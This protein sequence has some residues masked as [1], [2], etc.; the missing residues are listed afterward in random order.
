MTN[1]DEGL[2]TTVQFPVRSGPYQ[3][4]RVRSDGTSATLPVDEAALEAGTASASVAGGDTIVEVALSSTS[5]PDLDAPRG[6]LWP[7]EAVP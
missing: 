1:R 3:Y 2:E 7:P 5:D 6:Q 4:V